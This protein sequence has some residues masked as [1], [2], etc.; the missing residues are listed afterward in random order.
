MTAPPDRQYLVVED[1]AET[2][3][4]LIAMLLAALGGSATGVGTVAEARRWMASGRQPGKPLLALVDVGLP[5]GS[6]IDLIAEIVAADPEA[7]VV[8]TT[9][10]EDD[11]TLVAALSAGAQG[12]LLKDREGAEIERRL[13]GIDRGEVPI[14]PAIAR[15]LLARF[16]VP[17]GDGPAL[18]PRETE[19][20]GIVGRGLTLP[21]TGRVLGIGEQ[22]VA[23]HVKAI[24]RKLD[25]SSRAEAALEAR[26][27]GLA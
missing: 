21:E 26:R 23:S 11:E 6:G 25:I 4:W 19:V 3:I 13:A 10:H 8:V 9:I 1:I 24:Y 15:R 22:T 18:T 17:G 7:M 14:S 27:R 5:D 2:R 16:H 20:L 12:Y